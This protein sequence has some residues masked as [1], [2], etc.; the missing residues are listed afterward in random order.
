M[1][2]YDGVC[3]VG[4]RR[5]AY[6]ASKNTIDWT[7]LNHNS[8][9]YTCVVCCADDGENSN[10]FTHTNTPNTP[11]Y[12]DRELCALLLSLFHSTASLSLAFNY[13]VQN[14]N[15]TLVLEF[16]STIFFHFVGLWSGSALG[17]RYSAKLQTKPND[18]FVRL[19]PAS[20][21]FVSLLLNSHFIMLPKAL[22]K[23][24]FQWST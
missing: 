24:S 9:L 1:H 3:G 14:Q 16:L 21:F 8:K 4:R 5:N 20:K 13:F 2:I 10:S 18:V 15:L 6:Y 23:Y 19:I 17:S 11:H 7:Q 12:L 22:R